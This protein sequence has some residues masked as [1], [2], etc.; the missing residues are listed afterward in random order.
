MQINV[1]NFQNVLL[2]EKRNEIKYVSCGVREVA[3]FYLAGAQCS[4]DKLTLVHLQSP[5]HALLQPH[6]TSSV[7]DFDASGRIY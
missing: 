5:R 7:H 4:A 3:V 1:L 2:F 6:L